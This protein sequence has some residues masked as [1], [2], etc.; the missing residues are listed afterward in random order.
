M[1]VAISAVSP[2]F[3]IGLAAGAGLLGVYMITCGFFLLPA[4]I[5]AGWIWVHYAFSFHTYSFENFMINDFRGFHKGQI[6]GDNVL[7]NYSMENGSIGLN[8][9]WLL[10]MILAYRVMFYVFL[11]FFNKTNK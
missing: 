9:L 10:L 3:M 6:T 4:N 5:P 8:F 1:M 2:V 7:A 11:R